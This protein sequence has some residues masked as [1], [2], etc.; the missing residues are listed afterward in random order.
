MGSVQRLRAQA[1]AAGNLKG[2][3]QQTV[4]TE[5]QSGQQIIVI[6]PA[7]PQVVYV[8]VYNPQVVYY[9]PPPS[10]TAG[11]L[12]FAAGIAIGVAI[13]NDNPYP[14]Y[15]WG[16]WGMG[17][18]TN[19]VVVRSGVWVV[20]PYG[21]CSYVRPIAVPYGT[22]YRPKPYVYAPRTVNVTK[23][24]VN[25]P[26]YPGSARPVPKPYSPVARPAT[27][28]AVNPQTGRVMSAQKY[29][30][31]V[32]SGQNNN[33]AKAAYN[34][35]THRGAVSQTNQNGVK[36]TRTTQG[37]QATTKN[38]KGVATGPNGT[39]CARGANN[40]ACRP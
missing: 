24:T 30:N 33:G 26:G 14:P 31:G 34:P 8:P 37:G 36:T 22:A 29:P 13:A 1:Q 16:V 20:P 35:N 27:A 39:T 12:A 21:R 3:A 23:V 28:A 38:G 5:T 17:W 25:N 11:L 7:N 10:T 15:G 40:A 4:T 9:P 18:H 19:T 2:S 6:Q 32:T